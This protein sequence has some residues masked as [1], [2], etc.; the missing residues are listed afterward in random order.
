MP[1]LHPEVETFIGSIPDGVAGIEAT[2]AAMGQ[3]V[4]EYRRNPEVRNVALDIITLVP[5]KDYAAEA[6]AIFRYVQSEIRYT[7]DPDGVEW[8][9]TPDKT[10]QFGHGDCDDMATLLASLL[11]SIGKPTRFVAA[12]FYGGPIEHVW[13]EVK[14]GNRWFAM[15]PTELTAEFGWKPPGITETRVWH[16]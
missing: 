12:G 9:Q 15:D 16:N 3:I 4:R 7:Q 11:A 14:I 2:L 10:M 5:S 6:N 13:T 8:V 1:R